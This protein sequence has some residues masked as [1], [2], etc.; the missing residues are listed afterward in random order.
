MFGI[1]VAVSI[2]TFTAC[3]NEQQAQFIDD[4]VRVTLSEGERYTATQYT[5]TVSRG[6]DVTFSLVIEDGYLIAACSYEDYS[7]N[8]D[9]DKTVLTLHNVM[10]PEFVSFDVADI[11]TS[12]VYYLNGG[13]FLK[14]DNGIDFF[15]EPYNLETHLRVNTALGLNIERE[16]HILIGW[17]TRADGSGE[18]IGLGSRVT[19]QQGKLISLFA[20][21]IPC[22]PEEFLAFE[23]RED[24]AYLTAYNGSNDIAWLAIPRIIG[25]KE[26]VGIAADFAK[27]L[28]CVNV[29][30]S[31]NITAV[32]NGAFKFCNIVDLYITDNLSA[33][34]DYSFLHSKISTVHINAASKP[35]YLG[36]S[37]LSYFTDVIDRLILLS[38]NKKMVFFSGCSMSYG[39][40]SFMLDGEFEEYEIIDLGTIGGSNAGFQ[41]DILTKYMEEGDILIHAPEAMSD[42]QLMHN[43]DAEYRMFVLAESNYDLMS[44]AD[45]SKISGFFTEFSKYVKTRSGMKE[46]EYSAVSTVHNI[47]G[48][49][50]KVRESEGDKVYTTSYHYCYRPDYVNE[51]SASLLNSYYSKLKDNGV[52]IMFSFAPINIKTFTESEMSSRIWQTFELN[53]RHYIGDAY[54]VEI[55]SNA[56]N[57]IFPGFHFYDADY[58]LTNEGAAIRTR[59]LIEDLRGAI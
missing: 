26:I 25:G 17:N 21:W 55:I 46:T 40:D 24:G 43:N 48:D 37:E 19:V 31:D 50:I 8:I 22:V 10:Y 30:V 36:T 12:I 9:G 14:E 7:L 3:N 58:H 1:L 53:C 28:T 39:L 59:K 38:G 33:V 15:V 41:F 11:D 51:R 29:A 56:F 47:Y 57:Y 6:E 54:G 34:T 2:L 27:N 5:Q 16:N 49:N 32:E 18:H 4:E 52:R 45:I 23:E 35:R 42:Y 20:E 13:A 44:L